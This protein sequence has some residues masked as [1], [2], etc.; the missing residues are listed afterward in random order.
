MRQLVKED[1]S[2]PAIRLLDVIIREFLVAGK[3]RR[4]EM[5]FDDVGAL[6]TFDG[7]R[8]FQPPTMLANKMMIAVKALIDL[9]PQYYP[10]EVSGTF[11][12]G[13]QES[14]VIMRVL[15][16]DRIRLLAI[17]REESH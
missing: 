1:E 15:I 8:M 9:D 2:S 12:Y 4:V 5:R 13:F 14:V 7:T 17:E 3:H 10:R 6:V 11:A 16:D